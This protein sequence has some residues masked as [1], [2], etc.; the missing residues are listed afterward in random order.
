MS[1]VSER[2]ERL[3]REGS[4]AFIPYVCAGDPDFDFTLR[5]IE[6]L[7]KSGADIFEIGLPFSDP[8]ADGPVIQGAMNRS[9]S[10]GFRT[11]DVFDLISFS[12]MRGVDQPMIVMTYYNPLLRFGVASFCE[13]LAEAGGDG[14][15]VVDLPPEESKELDGAAR[16]NALDVVRLVAPSTAD[17]RLDFILS[18]TSGFVYAVSVAG[19]TGARIQLPASAERLLDRVTARSGI[20]VVLGFG[21]SSPSHVRA[22][23]SMGASG[24]VEGSRLISIYSDSLND[25]DKA[26]DLIE[27]HA[28]EMKTATL[29]TERHNG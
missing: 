11:K 26:L 2:F 25:K 7:A 1:R 13:K 18:R 6:R 9:L 20:P 14:L 10:S 27:S 21:V 23:L 5:Q 22:A 4:G 17:S 16:T 3:R 8:I 15:L 19:T 28:K 29:L 12:R 24:I